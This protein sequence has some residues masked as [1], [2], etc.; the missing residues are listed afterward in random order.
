[1][2]DFKNVLPFKRKKSQNE[3]KP[4]SC[5]GCEYKLELD[6]MRALIITLFNEIPDSCMFSECN[7]AHKMADLFRYILEK[8]II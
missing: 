6:N 3:K 7:C 4:D 5:D 1:M 8:I 2:N